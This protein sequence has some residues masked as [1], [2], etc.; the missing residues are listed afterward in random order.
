MSSRDFFKQSINL[1]NGP[2]NIKRFGGNKN[3][4]NFFK[5]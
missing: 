2:S 4:H 3:D 5:N 1:K